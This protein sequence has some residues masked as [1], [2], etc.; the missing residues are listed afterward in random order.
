M[1]K[2]P[3]GIINTLKASKGAEWLEA[4]RRE[5]EGYGYKDGEIDSEIAADSSA[6]P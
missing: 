6:Q 4:R 5:Y 2:K 3:S 1:N